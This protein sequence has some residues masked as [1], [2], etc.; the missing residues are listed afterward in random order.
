MDMFVFPSETET[1]F[2][3]A[4]YQKVARHT[5]MENSV[6]GFAAADPADFALHVS[7]LISD[8][9]LATQMGLLRARSNR[10]QRRQVWMRCLAPVGRRLRLRR[11]Q[12]GLARSIFARWNN[13]DP[14]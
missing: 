4:P 8:N 14:A 11:D 3:V 2:A 12:R 10:V 6:S 7:R 13:H 9:E 5:S 1:T